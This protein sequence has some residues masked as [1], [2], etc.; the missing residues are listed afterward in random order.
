LSKPR[1]KWIP[2]LVLLLLFASASSASAVSAPEAPPLNADVYLKLDGISGEVQAR[3]YENWIALE[4]VRFNVSH[5]TAPAAGSGGGRG[6]ATMNAFTA[7]KAWDASSVALFQATATGAS[8]ER[9]KLVFVRPGEDRVP[10]LTIDLSA[11][12]V[13]S[14]DFH[15]DSET[16]ELKFDAIRF[17][18]SMTQASGVGSPPIQGG[19]NFKANSRV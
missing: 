2:L 19:W 3:G 16:I 15:N 4:G 9:A 8:I 14:Y 13:A 12:S 6:K 1:A 7:T 5:S 11:V 18:Y 10:Y 17:S